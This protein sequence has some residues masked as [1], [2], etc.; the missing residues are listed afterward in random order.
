VKK[1][2]TFRRVFGKHNPH[3]D[4]RNRIQNPLYIRW[5]LDTLNDRLR[6]RGYVSAN[7]ALE[8][9]GFERTVK[10]GQAGW[11]RDHDGEGDGYID[12]GIWVHG[13]LWGKAWLNGE[14]DE[15]PLYFN[16]DPVTVSMPRRIKKLKAEGKIL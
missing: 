9:L 4:S 15:M 16:V 13:F 11:V 2:W 12:F 8:L 3:W 14:I 5:V 6:V 10:G 1:P 7:E